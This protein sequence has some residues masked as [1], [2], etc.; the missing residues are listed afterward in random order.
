M[1]PHDQA[2]FNPSEPLIIS[3]V[4]WDL[5]MATQQRLESFKQLFKSH[6]LRASEG[7]AQKRLKQEEGADVLGA[8]FAGLLPASMQVPVPR[9]EQRQHVAFEPAVFAMVP[10][11]DFFS[12]EVEQLAS[13]RLSVEGHRTCLA[14]RF[15]HLC[16]FAATIDG[17]STEET[18]PLQRC[19]SLLQHMTVDQCAKFSARFNIFYGTIGPK[20]AMYMPSGFVM[21][22]VVC[23]R[24][25]FFGVRMSLLT[26][27]LAA[28]GELQAFLGRCDS[29]AAST[30]NFAVEQL[31]V[32]LE[33]QQK[34]EAQ[35][36]EEGRQK[37]MGP[38]EK[39]REEK[40]QQ[41][42]ERQEKERQ[43]KE[44]REKEKELQD[45]A[46]LEKEQQE[47]EQEEKEQK[48][49]EQQEKERQEKEQ[50]EKEQKEKEKDLQE[51]E[52]Q[53][54]ELREKEKEL[55]EKA[56]LEKEQQ[57]REQEAK[58]QKQK[59]QQEKERQEKERQEKEQQ[60]KERQEKE[61]QEKE[62]REKEQEPQDKATL[63]KEQQEREQ[64][65]KEQKKKEQQEKERQEKEQQEK[66]QKE[67]EKD[68]H[69]KERQE[70]VL[71]EKEKSQSRIHISDPT[72]PY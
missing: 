21:A 36:K 32:C 1:S 56:R 54:K 63:E 64:E 15:T 57:E 70:Q 12:T 49:K 50:Q 44:G 13:L 10:G 16:Q 43:E 53:E 47:R 2:S 28:C 4:T 51:K 42:K 60:E 52:R 7:R 68:L 23:N 35:K 29:Q 65:E 67:K 58:E 26:K 27:D 62:G 41:E 9:D 45:K 25:D 17:S 6:P 33:Q 18:V 71:R 72:S 8:R 39:E 46:T 38:Q 61:R 19:F 66:E 48:K 3:N 37:E 40:E 31:A 55:Q 30:M 20:D 11:Q 22:E 59:E 34:Q 69:E 5:P 14:A 24:S